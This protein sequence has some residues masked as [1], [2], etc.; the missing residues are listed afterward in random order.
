MCSVHL[1]CFFFNN[2]KKK[3]TSS[4]FIINPIICMTKIHRLSRFGVTKIAPIVAASWLEIRKTEHWRASIFAAT[5]GFGVFWGVGRGW[6]WL[7]MALETHRGI[8]I[9]VGFS[10]P[11]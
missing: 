6:W 9:P 1:G 11:R 5:G 3:G 8:V 10:Q 7:I 2:K 4:P